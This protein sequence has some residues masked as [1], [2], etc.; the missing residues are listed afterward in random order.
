MEK[1]AKITKDMTIDEVIQKY[2]KSAV[3]FME[4]GFHCIGCP[5]SQAETV[6]Q[7]AELHQV[8]LNKLLDDLNKAAEQ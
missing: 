2:P 4:H 3:V 5:A 7:G 8:D 6:E 1:E